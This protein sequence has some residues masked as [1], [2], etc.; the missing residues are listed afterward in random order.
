MRHSHIAPDAAELERAAM[1]HQYWFGCPVAAPQVPLPHGAAASGLMSATA[2][3]LAHWLI[4][5][6]NGGG[7]AGVQLLTTAGL[8]ELHRG[9]VNFEA[10]GL[11]M[12]YAMGWF[13]SQIGPARLLWH[14]GTLPNFGAYM[15]LMP[16]RK[17]GLVLLFNACHHWMNPIL[18]DVGA[19]AAALVTGQQPT[20][21]WFVRLFPWLL[22]GQVLL[23]LVQLAG[24]AATLLQLGRW[25]RAPASRPRTARQWLRAVLLPTCAN[26]L[27]ALTLRPV[28]SQRRGY[29][30]LYLPDFSLLAWAC[31]GFALVWGLVRIGLVR[32]TL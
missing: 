30:K 18:I 5:H 28:L 6:L 25:R 8:D 10:F 21:I 20:P 16:E 3:D 31:G 24:V 7:D 29:L 32:R 2:E 17:L 27:P 13:V 23:P 9:A 26:L 4:A 11:P 19:G 22:R 15:A 14:S 12:Q 1:G